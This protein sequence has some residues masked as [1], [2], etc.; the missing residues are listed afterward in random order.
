MKTTGKLT[1]WVKGRLSSLKQDVANLFQLPNYLIIFTCWSINSIALGLPEGN[2]QFFVVALGGTAASLGIIDFWKYMIMAIVAI[3]GGFLADRHGR[4]WLIVS[5]TF[6]M[7]IS[8]VFNFLATHWYFILLGTIVN[9]FSLIYQPA[10][11]ALLQDSL[12]SKNRGTGTAMMNVAF[13]LT[14]IG[15]IFANM[16]LPCFGEVFGMRIIYGLMII[17]FLITAMLRVFKIQETIENKQRFRFREFIYVFPKAFKEMFAVRRFIS[18]TVLW[19]TITRTLVFV[20]TWVTVLI[21]AI[22]A[23]NILQLTEEQWWLLFIPSNLTLFIVS[24]PVGKIVDRI[25]RKIPLF[26]GLI[27]FTGATVI[28]MNGDYLLVIV[29]MCLRNLGQIMV[30]SSILSLTTDYVEQEYRGKING[31]NNTLAY[32]ATGLG[33][34]MGGQLYEGNPQFPFQISIGA[35]ILATVITLLFVHNKKTKEVDQDVENP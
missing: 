19:I 32:I 27:I 22:Y 21:N 33:S 34:Y 25:G 14:F 16:I 1:H 17:L 11:I 23:K 29:S 10:L 3:P 5:G 9:S 30:F 7:A 35:T 24:Y 6:I 18:R 12:G 20:A 13:S 15:S 26:V 4:R 2:F 28:F 31:F 8:Y